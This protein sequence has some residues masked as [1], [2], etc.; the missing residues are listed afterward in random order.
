MPVTNCVVDVDDVAPGYV[1]VIDAEVDNEDASHAGVDPTVDITVLAVQ[2]ETIPTADTVNDHD[3]TV[4]VA[5]HPILEK[6]VLH[7]SYDASPLHARGSGSVTN[8][9]LSGVHVS[10]GSGVTDRLNVIHNSMEPTMIDY[11][12]I[13]T[14]RSADIP[15]SPIHSSGGPSISIDVAAS[16][17]LPVDPRI[18]EAM[19]KRINEVASKNNGCFPASMLF[20]NIDSPE[21]NFGS[22][23]ASTV[24]APA[25]AA[26]WD[27]PTHVYSDAPTQDG[28]PHDDIPADVLPQTE[29]AENIGA[30]TSGVCG[31][32]ESSH[33]DPG[34]TSGLN[35]PTDDRYTGTTELLI[36]LIKVLCDACL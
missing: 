29:P 3:K 28:P 31:A 10:G 34:A 19:Q 17:Q 14:F 13:S 11:V 36:L 20:W 32:T 35:N 9:H 27:E 1:T 24:E 22:Q 8:T 21:W 2:S 7:G 23:F 25:D 15:H 5:T 30:A 33:V 12:R 18:A 6:T 4:F 16:E 26:I